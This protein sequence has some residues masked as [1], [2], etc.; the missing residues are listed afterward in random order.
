MTTHRLAWVLTVVVSACASGPRAVEP[1]ELQYRGAGSPAPSELISRVASQRTFALLACVDTRPSPAV[2]GIVEETQ[3]ELQVRTNVAEF[4]AKRL[5]TMLGAA[6]LQL[7]ASPDTITIAPEIVAFNVN[8]GG[9][10]RGD[11]RLRM[12]ITAPGKAP[13]TALYIGGSKRWGRSQNVEN[14]N[15][16]LSN[17]FESAVSKML[18]DDE[19]FG[20]AIAQ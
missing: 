17:A 7:S 19:G 2:V 10:Y 13:F 9:V 18:H 20:L 14:Y 16:T 4:C 1:F 12:T 5:T 6:G 11:V 3:A 8:E 15:E